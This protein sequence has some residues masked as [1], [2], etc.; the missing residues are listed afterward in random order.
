VAV[1][2]A[3]NVTE[4]TSTGLGGDCFALYYEAKS[5]KVFALNGS[6]RAPQTLSLQRLRQEGLGDALPPYHPYTITVPGACAGWFDLV[7]KFGSL[8]MSVLLAPSISLAEEGFKV[9]PIT[10][11]FW[12]RAAERQL[13]QAVNGSELTIGGRGPHAGE[14]FRNLGLARTLRT[15]AEKGKSAFYQG[16]IAEAIVSVVREAGGCLTLEDLA[17]H[18]STWDN[19]ISTDYRGLRIWECRR[20]GRAWWLFSL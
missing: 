8:P 11:Y 3:L 7:E 17:A 13:E 1:A 15:L 12:Q 4:P 10:S 6:G 16:E 20:T 9:A 19:P 18:H 14:L 5:R 2:A